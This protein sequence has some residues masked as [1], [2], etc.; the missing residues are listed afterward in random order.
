MSLQA[1][2]LQHP[3][4]SHVQRPGTLPTWFMLHSLMVQSSLQEASRLPLGSH[5]MALTSSWW[6]LKTCTGSGVPRRHT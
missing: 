2:L 3:D 5:L 1:A 4:A 6:P